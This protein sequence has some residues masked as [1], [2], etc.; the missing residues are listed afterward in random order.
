MWIQA[1]C[2]YFYITVF[3]WNNSN[4]I[5]IYQARYKLLLSSRR[6]N[7]NSLQIMSKFVLGSK[8]PVCSNRMI[9][10][11]LSTWKTFFF[12]NF[13]DV[14]LNCFYQMAFF[15]GIR[16]R[17]FNLSQWWVTSSYFSFF[18]CPLF[19][20]IPSNFVCLDQFTAFLIHP[21]VFMAMA[22][23]RLAFRK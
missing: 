18:V 6:M 8:R 4:A 21:I 10:L 19:K 12:Q 2:W 5:L 16:E 22:W 11:F 13:N 7:K 15:N 23:M 9:N 1:Y 20:D 14:C 3:I 17:Q